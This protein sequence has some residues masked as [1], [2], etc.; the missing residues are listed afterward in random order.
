MF[1]V[2]FGKCDISLWLWKCWKKHKGRRQ[3]WG[4]IVK[5]LI[6]A[7]KFGIFSISSRNY[8]LFL[9]SQR[10][11]KFVLFILTAYALTQVHHSF[12][13]ATSVFSGHLACSWFPSR[14]FLTWAPK[15][16]SELP[17]L[18]LSLCGMHPSHGFPLALR[19]NSRDL[20]IESLQG[21]WTRSERLGVREE[22]R[23]GN[24]S[25]QQTSGC[26]PVPRCSWA[27]HPM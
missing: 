9:F 16:Y 15:G 11:V 2:R 18:M 21:G 12:Q 1:R 7:R 22:K 4:K 20:V 19:G 27:S 25:S 14:P 24:R 13:T 17:N 26:H 3:K 10:S 8:Y 23:C 6:K 5:T